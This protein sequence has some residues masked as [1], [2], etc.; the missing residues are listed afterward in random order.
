MHSSRMHTTR[1]LTV[2]HSAWGSAQ[3]PWMQTPLMQNPW[4]QTLLDADPRDVDVDV[5]PPVVMLPLPT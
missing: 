1:L 2:S 4:M 5:D 3:S